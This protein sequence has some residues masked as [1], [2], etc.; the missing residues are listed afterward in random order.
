MQVQ[1]QRPTETQVDVNVRLEPQ[2]VDE[3]FK[4]VLR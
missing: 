3:V 1:V 4:R 2:E